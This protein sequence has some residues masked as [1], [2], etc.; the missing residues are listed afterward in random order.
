MENKRK[1]YIRIESDISNNEL[2]PM[3]DGID[4]GRESD[5]ESI[6]ND[7]DTEFVSDQPRSKTVDER[8]DM[9]TWYQ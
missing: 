4:S 9:F 1:K 8:H 3:L 5:V 6:L 7:S 2:L